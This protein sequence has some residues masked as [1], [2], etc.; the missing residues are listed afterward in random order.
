MGFHTERIKYLMSIASVVV[1][2]YSSLL[3]QASRRRIQ[4][5]RRHHHITSR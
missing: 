1:H 5:N 2:L 4:R 3:T